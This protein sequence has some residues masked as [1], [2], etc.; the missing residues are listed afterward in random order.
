MPRRSFA[1]ALGVALAACV[2]VG[3]GAGVD[4]ERSTGSECD[5]DRTTEVFGFG[6][7]S[8]WATV[9][10]GLDPPAPQAPY[11][12]TASNAVGDVAESRPPSELLNDL[13]PNGVVVVAMLFP[14]HPSASNGLPRLSLPLRLEDFQ[15]RHHWETQPDAR[16]PEYLLFGRVRDVQLDVRVYF[17]NQDPDRTQLAGAQERLNCLVVP[18]SLPGSRT[19]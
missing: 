13:P 12:V 2:V 19:S 10:T 5:G 8:G 7:R 1:Y 9:S 17:G 14:L 15:V 11:A 3:C 18:A 6:N 16:I 4:G